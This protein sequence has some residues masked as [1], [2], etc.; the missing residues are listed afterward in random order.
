MAVKRNDVNGITCGM[1][2][3]GM[4]CVLWDDSTIGDDG[5]EWFTAD[6][7]NALVS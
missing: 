3:N 2:T 7:F 5:F 6:E 4:R 1:R